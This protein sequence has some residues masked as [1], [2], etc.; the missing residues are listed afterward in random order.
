MKVPERKERLQFKIKLLGGG[1]KR[2][3]IICRRPVFGWGS[4]SAGRACGRGHAGRRSSGRYRLPGGVA[5]DSGAGSILCLRLQMLSSLR[6][7]GGTGRGRLWARACR[8]EEQWPVQAPRRRRGGLRRRFNNVCACKCCLPCVRKAAQ[9]GGACG[10]GHAGRR[11][12]GRYRLPG[13]VAA[14]LRRRF[15][16]MSAPANAVFP[17]SGRR[18]RPGAPVGAGMQ[19]GG[20]VAGTGSP[21]AS[22]RTPAPVQ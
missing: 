16:I 21:E 14:G 7:E 18:H 17:A 3:R 10:R 20:A 19:A 11:S 4:V 8:Q 6:R 5:A 13:G 2:P 22:R 9:V 1:V 15:N 12:S